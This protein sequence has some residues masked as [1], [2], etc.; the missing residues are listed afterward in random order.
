MTKFE[1]KTAS[2]ND[3][4]LMFEWAQAEKWG[5]GVDDPVSFPLTDPNGF[6]MGYWDQQ[7]ITSIA[8]IRYPNQQ[9][10]IGLYLVDP[11]YRGQG[12]GIQLWNKAMEYLNG[13]TI[14]L[15][16]VLAQKSNYE[17]SGFKL[18]YYHT[19]YKGKVNA[20]RHPKAIP[21]RD[22]PLNLILDYNHQFFPGSRPAFLSAF[23]NMPSCQSL[24][25]MENGQVTGFGAIRKCQGGYTVAP[26]FAKNA[27]IAEQ[28]FLSLCH[29]AKGES[30]FLDVPDINSNAIKLAIKLNLTPEFKAARMY[31]GSPPDAES[32]KIFGVTS[33]TVG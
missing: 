3:V 16:G 5:L 13:Y 20:V 18:A 25:M 22:L 30:V 29:Y 24:A 28:L 17:K 4:K 15:D 11:D 12:Y 26:L 7:P 6:F 32:S 33:M 2:L 14:G 31:N 23:F 27:D 1:I 8:A 19:H 10:F 9:A 21:A